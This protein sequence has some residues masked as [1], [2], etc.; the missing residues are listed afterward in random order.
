MRRSLFASKSRVLFFSLL[1]L[2]ALTILASGLGDV[3]FRDAQPI[4]RNS[5][6]AAGFAARGMLEAWK[7]IPIWLQVG[8]WVALAFLVILIGMM[9][10]PE[11][12]K[13]L[14]RALLR[15]AIT[16]WVL[17]FL[18]TRYGSVLAESLEAINPN[19][20]NPSQISNVPPPVFA[21]TTGMA[22]AA[23]AVSFLLILAALLI[24]WRTYRFFNDA[25]E[26]K[27][28]LEKIARVARSSI[29]ELTSGRDSTD[30]I[31][32]CYFRMSDAVADSRNLHRRDSMTPA[33][34]AT[35]LERAGLPGE[36]VSRLTRL[37]EAVRYGG[38]RSAQKDV[39]E[40]VACLNVI[41]SHCEAS[42]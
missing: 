17:F 36:A 30:A 32:N 40:A 38:Q 15:I 29:R 22:W 26:E 10:S 23:Y 35:R 33:E 31:M 20:N 28:S 19:A 16:Y 21:P 13:L 9:L 42:A 34:F 41:L 3:A 14:F 39:N 7:A 6:G 2:A 37:F 8:V 1:A 11:A 27:E 24:T 25:H 5:P 18:F 12:R 4:G